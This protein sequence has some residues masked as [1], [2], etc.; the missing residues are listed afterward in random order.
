MRYLKRL[1]TQISTR[2]SV[3]AAW[4]MLTGKSHGLAKAAILY[5]QYFVA[6]MNLL[7]FF[8][9]RELGNHYLAHDHFTAAIA[10]EPTTSQVLL[11]KLNTEIQNEGMIA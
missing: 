2:L 9:F 8:F 4:V 5:I 10:L 11:C 6:L 7:V 3:I 1:S